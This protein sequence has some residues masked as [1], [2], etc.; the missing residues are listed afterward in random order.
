LQNLWSNGARIFDGEDVSLE[1]EP[2]LAV[3]TYMHDLIHEERLVPGNVV[4]AAGGLEPQN[5]FIAGRTVFL[6]LLPSVAQA[7][8]SLDS[9][10]R[11]KVGITSP[12]MGPH[13]KA[14]VTFLSGWL[15]GIPAG[16]R[17]PQAAR[18]FIRF[19]TS[20]QVQKERALRG[21]PLPTIERIYTDPE[22][23]A[24]NPDYP[25]IRQMLRTAKWRSEI[26]QYPKVSR[27]IQKH[28]HAML[29]GEVQP[30]ECLSR[31]KTDIEELV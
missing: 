4:T 17:A 14:S 27:I 6:T 12:P 8:Q 25:K 9:P 2:T 3:L 18:E 19:M 22:V 16:A 24:F 23:L 15:Y 26:P 28:L 13:G 10:I 29:R 21:G 31:L 7:A 1:D 5:E 11:G 20:A 30:P